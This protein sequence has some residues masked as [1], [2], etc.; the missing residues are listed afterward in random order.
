MSASKEEMKTRGSAS[1]CSFFL[2]SLANANA[3]PVTPDM[4]SVTPVPQSAIFLSPYSNG[5]LKA[6]W[7]EGGNPENGWEILESSFMLEMND[8]AGRMP[9]K[10]GPSKAYGLS[11]RNV[12]KDEK[13]INKRNSTRFVALIL[14][15]VTRQANPATGNRDIADILQ[16][17]AVPASKPD[18]RA[19]PKPCD[20]EN[21]K[22]K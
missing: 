13:R 21:L 11:S 10:P 1:S 9:Q 16:A 20:L 3:R 8:F 12:R 19:C 17:R 4:K 6:H 14:W 22:R 5:A 7:R 15:P 2:K 18:M